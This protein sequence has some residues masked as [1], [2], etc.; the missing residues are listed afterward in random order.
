MRAGKDFVK[1]NKKTFL[2]N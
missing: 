2:C 1:K